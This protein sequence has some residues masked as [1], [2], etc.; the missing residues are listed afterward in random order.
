M[1]QAEKLVKEGKFLLF[2]RN[3]QIVEVDQQ[4][5]DSDWRIRYAAL[6]HLKPTEEALQVLR[7]SAFRYKSSIRRLVVVYLGD[8]KGSK[9]FHCSL[10]LWRILP[11]L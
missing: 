5:D 6:E 7:K 9:V 8:I 11:Y 10:R 2:V 1:A 3:Y 4:L